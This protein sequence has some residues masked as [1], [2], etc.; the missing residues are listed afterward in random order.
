MAMTQV[1]VV[2]LVIGNTILDGKF[3]LV[4][5]LMIKVDVNAELVLTTLTPLTLPPTTKFP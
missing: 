2:P 3:T 1:A 4:A 5:E